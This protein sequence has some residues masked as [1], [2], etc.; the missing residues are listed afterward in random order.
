MQILHLPAFLIPLR[1]KIRAQISLE[2]AC[3]AAQAFLKKIYGH[4]YY[5]LNNKNAPKM[6]VIADWLC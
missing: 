4:S 3:K 2:K 1:Q 6:P 5:I